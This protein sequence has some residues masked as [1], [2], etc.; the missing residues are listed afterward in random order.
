MIKGKDYEFRDFKREDESFV[1]QSFIKSYWEANEQIIKAMDKIRNDQGRPIA[2]YHPLYMQKKIYFKQQAKIIY[3]LIYAKKVTV[4][5]YPYEPDHI[6][7]YVIWEKLPDKT[8]IHY[9]YMKIIFRNNGIARELLTDI[10]KEDPSFY[11]HKT[12]AGKEVAYKLKIDYDP[13]LIYPQIK[14]EEDSWPMTVQR[15]KEIQPVSTMVPMEMAKEVA[16]PTIGQLT[17]L[18]VKFQGLPKKWPTDLIKTVV[19]NFEEGEVPEDLM[20]EMFPY[21]YEEMKKN[22]IEL[23]TWEVIGVRKNRDNTIDITVERCENVH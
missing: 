12:P 11:T 1:I 16:S 2:R 10:I 15:K 9:I 8:I 13:Y 5:C 18:R 14:G 6:L 21:L 3:W 20:K 4:V 23:S 22:P 19:K 7:G 17:K